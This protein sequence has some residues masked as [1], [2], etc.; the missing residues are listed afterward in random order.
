MVCLSR[1]TKQIYFIWILS[2]I[3]LIICDA[4]FQIV[5]A[6]V[7]IGRLTQLRVHHKIHFLGEVYGM[8][9][10]THDDIRNEVYIKKQATRPGKSIKMAIYTD[11]SSPDR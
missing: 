8:P 4:N 6:W 3:I 11:D 9:R 7:P 10:P 5:A 2:A 1:Q